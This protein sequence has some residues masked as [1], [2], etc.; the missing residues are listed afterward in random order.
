M[1]R[2]KTS[3][4]DVE[5]MLAARKYGTAERVVVLSSTSMVAEV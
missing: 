1:T 2:M 4:E 5:D 3:D